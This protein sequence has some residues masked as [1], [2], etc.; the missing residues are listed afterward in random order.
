MAFLNTRYQPLQLRRKILAF[1]FITA[2][3]CYL[4]WRPTIF[5]Y[6]APIFS[7]VLYLAEIF[8]FAML[9]LHLFSS[10]RLAR[11]QRRRPA[12]GLT[13]DVF[14]TA[15]DH[16]TSIVRRT[17]LATQNMHY[18]HQVWLLDHGN[19]GVLKQLAAELSCHYLSSNSQ[20][21]TKADFLNHALAHS[22]GD[23]FAVFEADHAPK[24]DFLTHTL[25]YFKDDAVAYVQ[26]P[27]DFY[28][29]DPTQQRLKRENR[30][31]W[32]EHSLF[33]RL[34]QPGKDYRNAALFCGSAAVLRRDA[35]NAIGGFAKGS[36]AEDLHTSLKLHKQ[37]FKSVY[38]PESLA[39]SLTPAHLAQLIWRK[40]DWGRGALQVW[41]S[42]GLL[43]GP[44]LTLAQ[45]FSYLATLIGVLDGWQKA[46][47]YILP[48]IV[49]ATGAM[50]V[51]QLA[52]EA[53]L[54]IAAYYLLGAWL[55]EETSRG[56]GRPLCV[57]QW[58]MARFA[59]SLTAIVGAFSKRV[60]PASVKRSEVA[61]KYKVHL[62]PQL[63]ILIANL[64]TFGVAGAIAFALGKTT[65]NEILALLTWAGCNALLAA[66]VVLFIGQRARDNR[67]ETRL[68]MP[69][70]A[71]VKAP[72]FDYVYGTIDEIS[73]SGFSFYGQLPQPE[74][75]TRLEGEIYLPSGPVKF[76]ASVKS[77]IHRTRG[78]KTYVKAVGCSFNW[79]DPR[80]QDK[81]S[82]FLYGSSL[83]RRLHSLREKIRTP[84]DG[85]TG[86]FTGDKDELDYDPARWA[87]I[88]Y[89][90]KAEGA[91][92]A[93]TGLISVAQDQDGLRRLLSYKPLDEN[94]K[95]EVRVVTRSRGLR[96][97]GIVQFVERIDSPIS[98]VYL[99][100]FISVKAAIASTRFQVTQRVGESS[101]GI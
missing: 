10:W 84:L 8:G 72:E 51:A 59:V 15:H 95:L 25:G 91:D 44:G 46:L 34:V 17:L 42:E 89:H 18:T 54:F 21:W 101:H 93:S 22:H 41:R 70:P 26:T 27:L 43:L 100:R 69:L 98:P 90:V 19:R 7:S 3:I 80:E 92:E 47:L 14:I 5:N 38:H 45:R 28:N 83:Q 77:L 78:D 87:T 32:T 39:F 99:Y 67:D 48:V 96:V 20:D 1:V 74:A 36:Q 13:V 61:T 16:P 12:D 40:T 82:L 60:K 29:L 71:K 86:I 85:L 52:P 97:G 73:C 63:L 50:P 11:R 2:A 49:L 33:Y 76:N 35:L 4:A 88:V 37:K 64:T 9:L 31:V 53:A 55:Y 62:L 94:A 24:H 57:Q 75:G 23:F 68:L 81:L 30:I 79:A 65:P 6:D 56:Y 58:N 66:T